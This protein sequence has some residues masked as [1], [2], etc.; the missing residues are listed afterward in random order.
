MPIAT[1]IISLTDKG[2]DLAAKLKPL[3][4]NS[5]HL[6]K[7]TPFSATLQ[8][9]FKEG[10]R[11]ILICATGIAVRSLAPVLEDKYK[12]PAVLVMDESGKFIIPLISGHEGGANAWGEWLAR[13]IGAQSIITGHKDYRRPIYVMGIG[14]DRGCPENQ[15]TELVT[16]SLKSTN[17]PPDPVTG[18]TFVSIASIELKSDEQGLLRFS[19][20][21]KL[22]IGFFSATRL[23]QYTDLLSYK[24]E[25]IFRE[26]G[27]YG[28][29]EAA[30]LA[31]AEDIAGTKAELIITKQKNTRAT[32]AVARAFRQS[33]LQD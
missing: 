9:L 2:Q 22:P 13:Q 7:P 21:Q 11:L 23:N 12:D 30:A 8:T 20:R 5:Q 28:V 6:H 33:P 19:E 31:A 29:A 24:S 18:D 1:T 4:P 26:T 10:H 25:I 15:I 14:C 17:L 3:Q 32:F 27:C 16:D